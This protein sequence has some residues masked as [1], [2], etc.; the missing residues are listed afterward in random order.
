MPQAGAV[1]T[2][3]GRRVLRPHL[4]LIASSTPIT[5]SDAAG[6]VCA[7]K[8]VGVLAALAQVHQQDLGLDERKALA[9]DVL[10]TGDRVPDDVSGS[11]VGY[12]SSHTTP[13]AN[14]GSSG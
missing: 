13:F 2:R 4:A 3:P 11:S 10:Q 14:L 9:I 12:G 8:F 7:N 5:R 1:V 6:W